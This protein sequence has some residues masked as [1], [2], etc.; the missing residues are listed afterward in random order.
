MLYVLVLVLFYFLVAYFEV[1]RMLKNRMYRELWVFVFLS[2]LGFTLALFQIFHW[3]FPNIT[4]GIEALFRPL[5]F[6]LEK[7]LLPNEP[8]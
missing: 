8:G 4:K 3:P 2:L 5:Y 1:P 7:L 6:R